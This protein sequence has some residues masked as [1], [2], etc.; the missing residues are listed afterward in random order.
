MSDTISDNLHSLIEEKNTW[1]APCTFTRTNPMPLD[2]KSCFKTYEDLL[3]YINGENSTAYP[4]MFVSVTDST[5]INGETRRDGAYVIVSNGTSLEPVYLGVRSLTIPGIMAIEEKAEPEG[6]EGENTESQS[7]EPAEESENEEEQ[8]PE[9]TPLTAEIDGHGNITIPHKDVVM[10]DVNIDQ[11]LVNV[12]GPFYTDLRSLIA[13]IMRSF[14]KVHELEEETKIEGDEFTITTLK[15][16][17]NDLAGKFNTL[18]T[19]L[20]RGLPLEGESI[21][22]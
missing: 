2:R 1:T 6:E 20:Q 13:Y 18:L 5:D 22:E 17:Y 19:I 10:D 4:G 11:L 14:S 7:Q 16:K 3:A 15:E 21:I 12:G 8:E 9:L